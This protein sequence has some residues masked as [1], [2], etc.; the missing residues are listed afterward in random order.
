MKKLHT[1]YKRKFGLSTKTGHYRYFHPV[2]QKTSR[3]RTF[4]TEEAADAWAQ[5]NGLK[6]GQYS[7]KKVKCDKKFQVVVKNGKDKNSTG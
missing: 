5:K 1:K 3:P 2:N 7:L 4:K 6:Q